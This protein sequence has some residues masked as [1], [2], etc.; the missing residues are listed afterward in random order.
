MKANRVTESLNPAGPDNPPSVVTKKRAR[1]QRVGADRGWAGWHRMQEVCDAPCLE[2][3]SLKIES[4]VTHIR[5]AFV[6]ATF[7]ACRCV[8]AVPNGKIC[9]A[10]ARPK[11]QMRSPIDWN[12][13]EHAR[14]SCTVLRRRV[15]LLLEGSPNGVGLSL[16]AK[17]LAV[18]LDMSATPIAAQAERPPPTSLPLGRNMAFSR[19]RMCEIHKPSVPML[20]HVNR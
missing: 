19:G 17:Q 8:L 16:A 7:W 4:R 5:R 20:T 3:P 18:I 13:F 14:L 15:A 1:W 11:S 10:Y 9:A 6:D 2:S 12:F